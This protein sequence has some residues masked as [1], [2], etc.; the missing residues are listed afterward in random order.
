[1]KNK[2]ILGVAVLSVAALFFSQ[3]K[4]SDFVKSV[5]KGAQVS[6][7]KENEIQALALKENVPSVEELEEDLLDKSTDEL[8]LEIEKNDQFA[9]ERN[10][11]ARANAQILPASEMADFIKTIRK[12]SVLHKIL[13]ERQLDEMEREAN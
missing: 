11:F 7:Q 13:L 8:R 4:E 1:M 12:N 3:K 6:I 9:K 10:F 5:K 2:I